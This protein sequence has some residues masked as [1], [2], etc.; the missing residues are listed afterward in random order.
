M[1]W[2]SSY[3]EFDAGHKYNPG[4][5]IKCGCSAYICDP[6]GKISGGKNRFTALSGP[7]FTERGNKI[8]VAG[9]L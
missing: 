1:S 8:I 5:L 3:P 6:D 2:Y 4:D 7:P 9:E